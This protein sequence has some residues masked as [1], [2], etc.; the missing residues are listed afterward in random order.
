M[1]GFLGFLI[2]VICGNFIGMI[3]M[4]LMVAS[5]DESRCEECR[6]RRGQ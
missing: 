5:G 3:L 1:S 6:E 2:G 4:G